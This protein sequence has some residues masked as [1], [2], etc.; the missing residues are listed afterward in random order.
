MD[1]EKELREWL[2]KT[3]PGLKPDRS[4]ASHAL[5]LLKT[6]RANCQWHSAKSNMTQAVAQLEMAR[7]WVER[8]LNE[9]LRVEKDNK[10]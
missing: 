6:E 8:A 7:G 4:T 9:L 10:A 1:D 5:E 2:D 3:Y